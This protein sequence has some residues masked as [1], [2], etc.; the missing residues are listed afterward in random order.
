MSTDK[1]VVPISGATGV[2]G[3]AIGRRVS[4]ITS[5]LRRASR[6]RRRLDCTALI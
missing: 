6:S 5:T 3:Y 1:T 4:H 2:I